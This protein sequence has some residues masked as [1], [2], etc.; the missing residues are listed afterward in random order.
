V[1]TMAKQNKEV[2]Q[3]KAKEGRKF[4]YSKPDGTIDVERIESIIETYFYK[5]DYAARKKAYN[6]LTKEE[7][8]NT[9]IEKM[10]EEGIYK[11]AGL[12][13]ALEISRETL[14][15]WEKGLTSDQKF[16]DNGEDVSIYNWELAD[17]IKKAKGKVYECL[18]EDR[19]NKTVMS[20]FLLKN[21]AGYADKQE[22]EVNITGS[23]KFDTGDLG[24]FSK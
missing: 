20:I 18:E 2:V 17:V 19:D 5:K 23:I 11:I 6:K 3:V 9:S 12:Y 10:T 7:Q 13:N 24:R 15:M 4:K 22:T 16:D 8:Q 14:N 21:H 1:R